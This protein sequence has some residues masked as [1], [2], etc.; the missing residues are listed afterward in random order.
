MEDYFDYFSRIRDVVDVSTRDLTIRELRNSN[1]EDEQARYV[2]LFVDCFDHHTE[3]ISREKIEHLKYEP[4]KRRFIS[5]DAIV[6]RYIDRYYVAPTIIKGFE[7]NVA[8]INP[9]STI[10]FNTLCREL[11]SFPITN[12]PKITVELGSNTYTYL[13]GDVGEGKSALLS[14]VYRTILFENQDEKGYLVF[15]VYIDVDEKPNGK[16]ELRKIDENWFLEKLQEIHE[17][18]KAAPERF[19]SQAEI[20]NIKYNENDS[21]ITRFRETAR[22]LAERKIRLLILIDNV[23]RYHFHYSKWRFTQDYADDQ[24]TSVVGNLQSLIDKFTSKKALGWCGLCVAF[25]CRDYVY[26]YLRSS[27]DDQSRKDREFGS[28]FTIKIEDPYQVFRSRIHLFEEVVEIVLKEK[29]S[30]R[31]N[32]FL[33]SVKSLLSLRNSEGILRPEIELIHRL[34]HHGF[35]SLIGFLDSLKIDMSQSDVLK[36]LLSEQ[37]KNLP[38]LY[39]LNLRARYSQDV[40]HFP[41]LFLVDA[42]VLKTNDYPKA[43]QP[44]KM[45]YWLKYFILKYLANKGPKRFSH[46]LRVFSQI[47]GYEDSLVRLVIGSLVSTNESRCIDVNPTTEVSGHSDPELTITNRGRQIVTPSQTFGSDDVDFCFEFSYLQLVIDDVLLSLPKDWISQ[48]ATQFDYFYLFAPDNEYGRKTLEIVKSKAKSVIIFLDI[49]SASLTVEMKNKPELN[50]LLDSSGIIPNMK[51]VRDNLLVAVTT[52][53]SKLES[54][55][56]KLDLP[57]EDLN[58]IALEV[59]F[60][61]VYKNSILVTQ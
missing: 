5:R 38:T 55:K 22:Y 34:G 15:P 51:H 11:I 58:R 60:Q 45:T 49:L 4:V 47:G 3:F 53:L 46:L 31:A 41:N 8:E 44:H 18:I 20:H 57:M 40:G 6:T 23:D 54:H 28:V 37:T 30:E 10:D 50:T 27:C 21:F 9:I 36:R 59:F 19:R 16:G 7:K 48:I 32:D 14:A 61:K 56:A 2:N 12:D 13:I 35:R 29:S 33:S 26:Q 43:F 1:L 52:V 42:Q 25:V 17:Q 24:R 39:L